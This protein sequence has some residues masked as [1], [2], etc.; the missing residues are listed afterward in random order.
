MAASQKRIGKVGFPYWPSFFAKT[1]E[2][3]LRKELTECMNSPPAGTKV[4]LLD[5]G[6]LHKWEIFMD[7]PEQSVYAVSLPFT[8]LT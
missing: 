4:R 5:D 7:G 1:I 6:D 8:H 3:M 2:L